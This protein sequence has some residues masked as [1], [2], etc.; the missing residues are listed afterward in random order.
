MANK[1]TDEANPGF[2]ESATKIVRFIQRGF[3]AEVPWD[4]E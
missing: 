1:D 2:L 4:S 3:E